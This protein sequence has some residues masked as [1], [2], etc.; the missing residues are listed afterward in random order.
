MTAGGADLAADGVGVAP[1]RGAAA[2]LKPPARVKLAY[3]FGQVVESGYLTVNTFVFFYY[4]A[5]LG[6]IMSQQ[7]TP[8]SQ[9]NPAFPRQAEPLILKAMAKEPKDRYQSAAAMLTALAAIA[10]DELRV[11]GAKTMATRVSDAFVGLI[12]K[13]DGEVRLN[14]RVEKI[15]TRDHAAAG[16]RTAD[17]AEIKARAVISTIWTIDWINHLDRLDPLPTA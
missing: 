16:V 10:S 2:T 11:I 3:C 17:G 4:T 5:V 6:R 13:N 14:T 1:P 15:L 7:M 8:P 9:A 12:K